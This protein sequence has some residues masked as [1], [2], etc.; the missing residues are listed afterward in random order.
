MD[1]TKPRGRCE[2]ELLRRDARWM[3]PASLRAVAETGLNL[4]AAGSLELETLAICGRF[5]RQ[6]RERERYDGPG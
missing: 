3:P 1:R 2:V 6:K 5:F 4:A